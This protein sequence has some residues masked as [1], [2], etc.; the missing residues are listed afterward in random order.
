MLLCRVSLGD[1]YEMP[2]GK[3][4]ASLRLPPVKSGNKRHD[5]VVGYV[6][7]GRGEWRVK[8]SANWS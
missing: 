4:D 6:S 1:Y 5:S 3:T 8:W 2:K 7:T